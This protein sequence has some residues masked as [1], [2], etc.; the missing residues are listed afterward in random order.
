MAIEIPNKEEN[1][2]IKPMSVIC[3]DKTW[4]FS[5]LPGV[6]KDGIKIAIKAIIKAR[7]I[8]IIRYLLELKVKKIGLIIEFPIL[9]SR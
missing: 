3:K 7:A 5:V 2:D 9:L 4:Y 8:A 1:R 6:N